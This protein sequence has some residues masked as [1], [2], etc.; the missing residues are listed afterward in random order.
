MTTTPQG[1]Y[2][3]PADQARVRWFDGQA[4]TANTQTAPEPGSAPLQRNPAADSGAYPNRRINKDNSVAPSWHPRSPS[5]YPP[6][7]V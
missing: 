5:A 2:R 4:W 1:W 7:S 3:D 6:K